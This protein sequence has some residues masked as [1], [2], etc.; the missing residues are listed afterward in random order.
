MRLVDTSKLAV[1]LSPDQL[2]FLSMLDI[3]VG[4]CA[5]PATVVI[6]ALLAK[7][8]LDSLEPSP[9]QPVV[10]PRSVQSGGV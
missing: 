10:K 4:Y 1:T 6:V 8:V 9:T 3:I 7:R 5:W 2:M